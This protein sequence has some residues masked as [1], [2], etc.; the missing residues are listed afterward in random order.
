MH[1]GS[2]KWRKPGVGRAELWGGGP[3]QL[4]IPPGGGSG[5]R[6]VKFLIYLFGGGGRAT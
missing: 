4:K 3:K 6:G 1:S 2:P 5:K